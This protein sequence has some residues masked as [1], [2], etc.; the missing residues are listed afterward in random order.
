MAAVNQDYFDCPDRA[1]TYGTGYNR[2]NQI[3]LGQSKRLDR[4]VRTLKWFFILTG[5]D[6]D[7]AANW[8]SKGKYVPAFITLTYE[9]ND[10]WEPKQIT[11]FIRKL[12][13]FAR[14]NWN[15]KLRYAWVAENQKRGV[16]HYHIVCWHPRN[17]SF[18]KP[19]ETATDKKKGWWPYGRSKIE[20][21]RKGVYT[22]MSKYMTKSATDFI[23]Y[24]NRAG[25]KVKA[26]IFGYGG[27]PQQCKEILT[28][29]MVPQYVKDF[30][31]HPAILPDGTVP[32]GENIR[33]VKG[34]WECMGIFLMSCYEGDFSPE[35][36]S[37]YY[38]R[39]PGYDFSRDGGKTFEHMTEEEVNPPP[40]IPEWYPF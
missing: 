38:D 8:S 7:Y 15:G 30:F 9:S 1:L 39:L 17:I 40:H 28:H 29:V 32:W 23:S 14:Y 5:R 31:E 36:G 33:R 13:D 35:S 18:P 3:K 26:H 21:V 20:G 24:Q 6:P 2:D 27:L 4:L 25:R 16:I 12:R 34:G 22:Y 37:F 11:G 19:S 10:Q